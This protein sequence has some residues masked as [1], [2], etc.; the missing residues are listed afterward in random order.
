MPP[1]FWMIS[2]REVKKNKLGSDR[3]PGQDPAAVLSY[4]TSQAG[5]PEELKDLKAWTAVSA[6]KFKR[7][8]AAVAA[9]FPAVSD[10]K[11]EEQKHVALFIHG[12]NNDWADAA[13]MY[14]RIAT[15]LF[16]QR[17][18]G[19]CVLFTWPSDGKKLGYIPDRVDA[20][21]TAPDLSAVFNGLYDWALERQT[22]AAADPRKACR[23]KISVI[24]HSMGNYV[25]QKAMQ[26]TWTRK[27]QP[28]LVSLINQLLMV[29]ADVDN[30]LFRGGES[31]DKSDG[32]AI[33]NLCYRITALYSRADSVLGLSAGFK[34][35]GKRR[36][37]RAGLDRSQPVPDNVC[38]ID[39]TS[40]ISDRNVHSAYFWEPKTLQVMEEV[41]RGRDRYL[42]ST[43]A[44][45]WSP[46]LAPA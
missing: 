22:E 26:Y 10:E 39:C 27:N 42:L 20:R 25:M 11:N 3:A 44:T 17:K 12:Y 13:G 36:L 34:H 31:T 35:F 29:A 45:A 4:W 41:L 23:A 40:L 24:A 33:A 8:L 38:D 21:A 9:R 14:G 43:P 7:E 5:T 46:A 37:G 30:D 19:T 18:L 32:D 28:L 16:E 15:T 6:E 2:N 1:R